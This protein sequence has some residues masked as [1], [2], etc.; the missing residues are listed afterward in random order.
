MRA[1]KKRFGLIK[2]VSYSKNRKL[3]SIALICYIAVYSSLTYNV[4]LYSDILRI[5]TVSKYTA[6]TAHSLEQQIH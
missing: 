6:H 5:I 3:I 1:M 4:I 2:C